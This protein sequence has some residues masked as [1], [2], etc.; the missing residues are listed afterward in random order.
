[1]SGLTIRHLRLGSGL[2]MWIY[3]ACHFL[4]HS[5]GLI[6]L[7]AAE[8]GLEIAAAVWQSWPGTLLLY[9]AF[10]LHLALALL[11]LH[12]RHSLR[13]P[14]L[15]LMRIG[16]GLT[17]PLLL[18]GHVVA[19]RIAFSWYGEAAQYQRVIA[20]LVR[21]GSTGWQLA[22][23]APGWLHGCMGL[24]IGFRHQPWY[25]S[26][27]MP[28]LVGAAALPALAAAGYWSMT[29]DVAVLAH[30]PVHR[31]VPLDAAQRGA[32]GD[33]RVQLLSSYFGL[34]GGVIAARIWRDWR[35]WRG[36]RGAVER[37]RWAAASTAGA[38]Q[39]RRGPDSG[40]RSPSAPVA[41]DPGQTL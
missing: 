40:R 31:S 2:A 16:F 35:S 38:D 9:G 6:S 7:G 37:V 26:L 32:L 23:L 18:F 33:L 14:P 30:S 28:L 12:Q 19:T 11:G 15:E 24:N 17:I 5:L 27:R 13:L 21:E 10:G 39:G 4:N 41:L 29:L 22:L 36:E 8:R 3:I 25:P 20:S 34:L 1:M